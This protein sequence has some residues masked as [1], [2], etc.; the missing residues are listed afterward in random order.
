MTA[1][2]EYQQKPPGAGGFSVSAGL[3]KKI[4]RTGARKGYNPDCGDFEARSAR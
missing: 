1:C 2:F 4:F 3:G